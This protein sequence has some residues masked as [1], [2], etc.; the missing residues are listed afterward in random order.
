[1]LALAIIYDLTSVS[2]SVSVPAWQPMLLKISGA[3]TAVFFGAIFVKSLKNY[4]IPPVCYAAPVVYYLVRLIY[5]FTA[6]STLALVSDNLLSITSAVFTVLF[7]FEICLVANNTDQET[8]Y[9]RIAITGFTAVVFCIA[10]TFPQLI[11]FAF[12]VPAAKRVEISSAL[13]TFMTGVF[14]FFF[15]RRHFSGKNLKSRK[16]RQG[17]R[18]NFMKG[19]KTDEFYIG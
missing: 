19:K 8:G 6:T 5:I 3:V 4:K 9:K 7:M 16:K 1:M 18:T 11:A 17:A 13:V 10:T 14:I 2:F 12:D 15:L